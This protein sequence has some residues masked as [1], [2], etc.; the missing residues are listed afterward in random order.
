MRKLCLVL[1]AALSTTALGV[2]VAAPAQA[3]PPRPKAE[4]V[5][6]Q[7]SASILSGKVSAGAT[8]K[9]KGN[10]LAAASVASF[11]LSADGKASADD[12]VLGTAPV[13]KIKPKKSKPASGSFA[14]TASV[15]PGT[16][17]VLVC[18][19]S[20]G[21]VKERKETNNCK[22]SKSTVQ[23][24]GAT[25]GPVTVSATT[26]AGG[27][28]ATSGVSGGTCAANSCTFPT[29]GTG[30]VT[31]T[32][33]A[34]GGYRFGAWSGA[35]C[36]GFTTGA[37][38]AI[39]FTNPTSN[40]ACT[41]TFVQQVTISY[42]AAPLPALGTVSGVATHGT[43]TATTLL[44][45]T[46]SC[47]VDAGVGTVTLT[48]TAVVPIPGFTGWSGATCNGTA[49]ANVMTFTAPATDKACTASFL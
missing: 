18:A 43:C 3:K 12:T 27:T 28:V 26:S 35:S 37:G 9:N 47:V 48:A 4:L 5:T 8:V 10:K 24:T 7:V 36:T 32:P 41:A 49:A 38:G 13:G 33:T 44:T 29:V 22:A 30:T 39:T 45:A 31:F 1:V 40:K 46:G 14:I 19:D 21:A 23:V 42:T 15:V 6:K 17:R 16:Y 2:V 20:G 34:D 11:S 25:S